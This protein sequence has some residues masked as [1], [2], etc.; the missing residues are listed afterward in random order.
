M[1]APVVTGI[2]GMLTQQ[3]RKTFGTTPNSALLKT[4]IIAGADNLGNAGPDYTYGFGLADAKASADLIRDDNGTGLRIRSGS[5]ANGQEIDFPVT[6][7]AAQTFRVVLGWFD[8]EVLLTPDNPDDD[9]LAAKTLINDLDVRVI[10]PTGNTIL[11]YVLNGAT[12]AAVATRGVNHTDTTEEVDV[13]VPVGRQ[14]RSRQWARLQ[15]TDLS[16]T[17]VEEAHVVKG[18]L[19]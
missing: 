7:T 5:I 4:L 10:D 14:L 9:P 15:V 11:P 19:V 12:P 16:L 17:G 13:I 8:P 6:L 18:I 3:Y 1:S 2:A